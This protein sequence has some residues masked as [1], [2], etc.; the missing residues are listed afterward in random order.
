MLYLYIYIYIYNSSIRKECILVYKC[1]LYIKYI[2][3]INNDF[4]IFL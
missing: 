3:Y 4:S 1:L 2:Q